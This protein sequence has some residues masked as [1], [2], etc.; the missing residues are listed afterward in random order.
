LFLQ[1]FDNRSNKTI[2]YSRQTSLNASWAIKGTNSLTDI[3]QQDE[4][5][6][7]WDMASNNGEWTTETSTY[8]TYPYVQRGSVYDN[9]FLY[10]SSRKEHYNSILG[11]NYY[12][13]RILLYLKN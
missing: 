3:A 4:I 2:P 12:T 13:F 1:E 6:N 8:S 10:T 9:K 7:I 5:C 11:L